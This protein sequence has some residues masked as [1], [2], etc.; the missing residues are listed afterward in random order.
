MSLKKISSLALFFLMLVVC[1]G[2]FISDAEPAFAASR[3]FK[4][5]RSVSADEKEDNPE[6]PPPSR[7]PAAGADIWDGG[8]EPFDDSAA[9][10]ENDPYIIDT[11][12]KLAYLAIQVNEGN[13]YEGNHYR[14]KYFKM[15]R[16]IDLAGKEWTP[17]G[18]FPLNYWVSKYF[19]GN[20]DGCGYVISNMKVELE[21]E[22]P[23][24]DDVNGDKNGKTTASSYKGLFGVVKDGVI[25]RV[26]LQNAGVSGEYFVGTLAG[27]VQ[28]SRVSECTADG[29]VKGE[30]DLAGGL[31]GISDGSEIASCSANVT[32][33]GGFGVGGLVGMVENESSVS[34]SKA[35][36]NVNGDNHVGGL[37]GHIGEYSSVNKS[38][39]LGDVEGDENVGGLA[40][41]NDGEL[42]YSAA[43]GKPNGT[44]N[45]SGLVGAGNGTVTECTRIIKTYGEFVEL[46]AKATSRD[47]KAAIE[48]GSD[49]NARNDG[50]Y[51]VLM[52]AAAHDVADEIISMLTDKGADVNARTNGGQTA[53]MCSVTN[54]ISAEKIKTLLE[55]GADAKAAD[56]N[57]DSVLFHAAGRGLGAEYISLFTGAGLDVNAQ[58]SAG[59]TALM[60]YVICPNGSDNTEGVRDLLAAGAK[61]DIQD[62][63]GMTALMHACQK[64]ER[65]FGIVSL[66][67][68][69]GADIN[70]RDNENKSAAD[71]AANK[72]A[73]RE[74]G[75]F[76]NSAD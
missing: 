42:R 2:I 72:A 47:I 41:A 63:K 70:I 23:T 30:G 68:E 28:D 11:A 71:Y 49:V 44:K 5:I 32:V 12:E 38:T 36:G 25:S 62:K 14:G 27:A 54:S 33:A 48:A 10:D 37:V 67:I 53:L 21:N 13:N 56:N 45:V 75:V 58:N 50:G 35:S 4:E 51:T 19:A 15:T 65:H 22:V 1:A 16:D 55:A 3:I 43:G 61:I 74:S 20:F 29:K 76:G 31:L 66:L 64:L 34:G 46:I 26:N 17:I 24:F 8:A 73:L 6:V 40:G 59:E 69:A 18:I 52:A 7:Q 60:R 39:A 57:G 9:G